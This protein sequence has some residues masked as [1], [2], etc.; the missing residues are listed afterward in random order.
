M[1]SSADTGAYAE[2]F[3]VLFSLASWL[4]PGEKNIQCWK[5]HVANRIIHLY[6]TTQQRGSL[7]L[8]ILCSGKV[9]PRQ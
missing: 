3:H 4:Y 7:F 9:A 8:G 1:Y 6:Y 5:Y 2:V